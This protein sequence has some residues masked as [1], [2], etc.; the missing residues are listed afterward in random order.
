VP[1]VVLCRT[2]TGIATVR[3]LAENGVDVRA[4]VFGKEDP[5]RHSRYGVKVPC[6]HLQDDPTALVRLLIAYAQK[7]GGRPV[8]L[9][10]CDAHAL[11]LAEYSA[12][13][14]PHY[15]LWELPYEDLGRIV[16]KT[17]LYEAAREAGAPV[18]PSLST[19]TAAE[20][21]EW[22]LR[23][24]G[25]YLLKPSYDG[26]GTCKLRS[27]NL[28]L[29]TREQLLSHVRIH[30]TESLVI[31]RM[32]RGGD[33]NI[34]DCYGLCDR[35][36]RVVSLTS[37]QRLRQYPPD[38]GATSMGEIP[39]AL[40]A[41]DE[42]F[43]FAATERLFNTV[44]FH[45]IFG[46]EWL[47]E[48]TTGAFYLIDFN[49]RPFLTIGHLHD[50]GVNLP[51]LAYRELTGQS[52]G[53]VEPR[54]A[55]KRKRWVYFSKDIDTFR[56]LR[57]TSRLGFVSWLLSLASCRSF[58]YVRWSDPLPGMHSLVNIFGRACLFLLRARKSDAAVA[59]TDSGTTARSL[60]R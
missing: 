43:L 58:A 54:P 48:E 18:I 8:L 9:P 30:G 35:D 21:V 55:V 6:Y 14:R 49:A 17:N 40:P 33:G 46:I 39:A 11:M 13:L 45:G 42:Q 56:E 4:F 2:V 37:H 50:C 12:E 23:H 19:P 57:A 1:A 3:A 36:G 5:L 38:F 20:V 44:K 47:R 7:I 29:E 25:P 31:Q 26:V 52:L 24:T 22:S 16:N 28:L 27:K 51:L 15:R 53:G 41:K 10:T 32:I 59:R 60:P 34:F